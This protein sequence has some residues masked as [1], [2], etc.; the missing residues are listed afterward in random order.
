MTTR[1]A[2]LSNHSDPFAGTELRHI[3]NGPFLLE[4]IECDLPP[5][6]MIIPLRFIPAPDHAHAPTV[7]RGTPAS[8]EDG[9]GVM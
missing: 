7:G 6:A 4:L 2:I 9:A 3:L 1:D 8:V 5:Y